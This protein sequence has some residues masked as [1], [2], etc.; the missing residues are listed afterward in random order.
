[1]E[2]DME[3][4]LKNLKIAQFA[5]EET[6]C[7]EA[8]VYVNGKKAFT[9]MNEGHGGSNFYHA[10]DRN[11]YE[12]A[13]HYANSIHKS[14]YMEMD[15]DCLIDDLITNKEIE[16]DVKR[17][18]NKATIFYNGKIST[19][20]TPITDKVREFIKN[21]YHGAIIMNDISFNDAVALYRKTFN[22]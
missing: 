19:F 15:L 1:M 10:I 12:Q 9:A 5:S 17:L 2:I 6:T 16:K 11:L 3:I 8:T 13:L 21:K 4:T 14:K 20:K 18:L 22:I 7:F